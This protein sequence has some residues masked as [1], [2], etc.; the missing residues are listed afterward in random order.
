MLFKGEPEPK[1]NNLPTIKQAKP[2]KINR[3]DSTSVPMKKRDSKKIK[4][5]D[6]TPTLRT[7]L[8]QPPSESKAQLSKDNISK[9]QRQKREGTANKNKYQVELQKI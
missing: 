2:A 4:S 3:K 9:R 1:K 7:A 5:S 6:A 8:K